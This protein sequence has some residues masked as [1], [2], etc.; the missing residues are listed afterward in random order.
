MS[1][2]SALCVC[3]CSPLTSPSSPSGKALG[4]LELEPLLIPSSTPIPPAQ[5]QVGDIPSVLTDLALRF[6][7]SAANDFEGG[8]EDILSP[9][10]AKWNAHLL[11]NKLD[12]GGGGAPGSG[13]VGWRDILQAVQ[14]LT[15]IKPI[16]T[17]LTT[18]SNWNV[19]SEPGASAPVLEYKSL[20]GPLMRLS[21][22]P[23]GAVRPSRP[24]SP[25]TIL[26]HALRSHLCLSLTFPSR[27]RWCAATSTAHQ[28]A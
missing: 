2:D 3:S 20:L 14:N 1:G 22:F 19:A 21:T 4:A 12:I 17:A 16:A 23:D 8:I 5:L 11:V 25:S 13:S 7:P 6:T 24:Y 26:M 10:F 18:F 9:L 27:A 15:E 28:P